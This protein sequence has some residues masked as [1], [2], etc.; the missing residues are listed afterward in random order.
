M[1]D[2][3][4]PKKETVRI[5]LP[6]RV[7][8]AGLAANAGRDTARINL[9]GKPAI[10]SSAAEAPKRVLPPPPPPKRMPPPPPGARAT[11]P[12]SAAA[13]M[14]PRL[15]PPPPPVT[16]PQSMDPALSAATPSASPESP[17]MPA[18]PRILPPP[19][20][21]LPPSGAVAAVSGAPKS[22]PGSAPQ[23]G[24]RKE[25][26]RITI[27]PEPAPP[28]ATPT[29]KMARTQPLLTVPAP[30]GPSAP[31]LV[32]TRNEATAPVLMTSMLDSV[33][34]PICWT[35]FGISAVTLLIQIWNYFE[36]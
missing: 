18:R 33:P 24:P 35:I 19:P 10:V 4:G 15:V 12:I 23:A 28:P 22:Y 30:P 27:L 34:L 25:T 5:T 7:G 8:P 13:A 9:P 36:S 26:A 31:I 20:R 6:P 11:V 32:A 17:P 2:L 16:R 21:V 14:P 29:V 1:S 3:N